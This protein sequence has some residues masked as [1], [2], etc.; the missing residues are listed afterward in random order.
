MIATRKELL[1]GEPIRL[2]DVCQRLNKH[3]GTV[4]RWVKRGVNGHRLN[5]RAIGGRWATTWAAV[6]EFLIA[7][8]RIKRREGTL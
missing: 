7:V 1:S 8:E 3:R 4:L 2:I 5:G 6:D